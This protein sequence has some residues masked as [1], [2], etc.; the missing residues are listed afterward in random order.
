MQSI[1]VEGGKKLEGEVHI[2][3]SKNASL[4]IIAAC[5]LNGG[6]SKLYNVPK[7]HDT[8]MMYKILEELGCIVKRTKNKV[9]I[10]SSKVNKYEIPENLMREM[11]SSVILAGAIIGKH[12]QAVFSYPGGCDIGTRP[13]DLHLKSFEK[14]GI[15]ISKKCGNISCKCDT[16]ENAKIDLD[17]PSVGA[18]ENIMLA[19]CLGNGTTVITNAAREPE[20]I[21]LQNFLNRMGAKVTG[22]GTNIIKIA[23]VEQLKDVSY[24]IM[25]D[26]IEAGTYLCAVAATGGKIKALNVV[27]EHITP[28]LN[29]LEE[30]GCKINAEK[31]FVELVAPKRIKA[32]NIKTMPYPGF[33]TDMQSIFVAMLTTAKGTSLVE[34]NVFENRYKF[35]QELVRMG[36]KITV[37]GKTAIINGTKK[38]NGANVKATDLRGGMALVIAA[39]VAKNKTKIENIHYILR[40]Y[41]D[42]DK[43]LTNLGAKIFLK[44]GE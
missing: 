35:V 42:L 24:N 1:I 16:I 28:I 26:R 22:A 25:P 17:F 36:A 3:G 12:H 33:P 13:I 21:D 18:T 14:L 30:A 19:S 40:G 15:L 34:E 23:G 38:V 41:E 7:I 31:N 20:I 29:K 4:P 11:R 5:I 44:E 8:Q 43:K 39:L 27:P 6:T 9:I 37:S 32:V 2:S 10:D